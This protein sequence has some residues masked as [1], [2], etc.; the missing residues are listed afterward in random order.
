MTE[1]IT[2]GSGNIYQDLGFINSEEWEVKARLASEILNIMEFRGWTQSKAAEHLDV[3][4]IE[5]SNIERGQFDHFTMDRL[6][7]YLMKL[8]SDVQI[9]I[10]RRN[11]RQ[12][13]HL[14]VLCT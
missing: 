7:S 2:Q 12:E 6:M 13:G 4:R 3:N 1:K 8:N 10:K 11:D 5:L 9:T 14:A